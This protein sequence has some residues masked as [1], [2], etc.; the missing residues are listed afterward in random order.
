[1]AS[2]FAHVGEEDCLRGRRGSGTIFFGGCNL[3]C[4][5]CQNYQTS[6]R[7]EGEAVT[8]SQ[9]ASLMLE[10]QGAGC[11]NV[12]FVTPEHVVPQ[13]LESLPEA[14]EGG[15]RV[16]LV[17]NTSGYDS[18]DSIGLLDGVVDIY[19]PDFKFWD[20][21]LSAKYLMARDYPENARL[22]I[23]AMHE[24]VGVLKVDNEGVA[25][26][27]LLIRH[28]VMPGLLDDTESIMSWL[29]QELSRDTFVNVMDQY[30]PAWKTRSD[31]RY[32]AIN[33][34]LQ[35]SE[36]EEAMQRAQA[37]GLWRFDTR[38]RRSRFMNFEL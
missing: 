30:A 21:D 3:H 16:P 1:V 19:M 17:Y 5:F 12:N 32:A 36:F 20:A 35:E 8:S 22:V 23:K 33:R 27:G 10:L 34:R 2:A 24:Q 6:Q 25:Q 29:A 26:R 11:H 31:D 4:V 37:A 28:L 38:W 13:I 14:I 9:L 18:L 15:L 7:R